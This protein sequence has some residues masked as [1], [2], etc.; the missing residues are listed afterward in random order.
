MP[1][2]KLTRSLCSG[3]I[4][5]TLCPHNFFSCIK[6][7]SQ[8]TVGHMK[9]SC[10]QTTDFPNIF[11][12]FR[13]DLLKWTPVRECDK[14]YLLLPEYNSSLVIWTDIQY[15]NSRIK[16]ILVASVPKLLLVAFSYNLKSYCGNSGTPQ[17]SKVYRTHTLKY[18]MFSLGVKL[19]IM[20]IL[21]YIYLYF[22]NFS[23]LLA[24]KCF[25]CYQDRIS[26]CSSD[27][28]GTQSVDFL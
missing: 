10:S 13:K 14:V 28:P 6:K 11:R 27:C 17:I 3:F 4:I 2:V 22:L 23:S 24:C 9:C 20:Y 1:L 21:L 19:Q 18:K 12:G 25:A 8:L 16:Q 5:G 26:L 15:L 7:L